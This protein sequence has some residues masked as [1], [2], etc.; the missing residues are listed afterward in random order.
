MIEIISALKQ[1][2]IVMAIITPIL[3][4]AG[5]YQYRKD[6]RKQ[7]KQLKEQMYRDNVTSA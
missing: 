2:G 1:T 4:I 5:I 7:I 3:I 6:K